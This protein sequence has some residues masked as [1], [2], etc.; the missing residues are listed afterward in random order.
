MDVGV[1]T[2][3]TAVLVLLAIRAWYRSVSRRTIAGAG[4]SRFIWPA[5]LTGVAIIAGA[6]EVGHH[7]R[8]DLATDALGAVTNV[9]GAHAD[10]SRFTEEL[11]NI[12]QYQGYVY[13]DGSN[14]AH[15]RR[16]VCHDLW[17]YA[18]GGQANP[19]RSE[20]LAVHIVAHEAMH[21]NGLR[22]EAEAEC[23]AVQLNH[24]VAEELGASPTQARKLQAQYYELYYPNQRSDY[25]SGACA[26][27]GTMDIDADRTEFP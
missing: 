14:T 3:V 16:N 9:D 11:F 17:S 10:C 18:H 6:F 15:L 4:S 2:V 7:M 1:L 27:G 12:S 23:T 22:S 24:L 8:Q 21:I 13:Y 26:E 25:I 20:I 5:V 19:S